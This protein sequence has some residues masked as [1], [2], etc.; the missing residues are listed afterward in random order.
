M[1]KELLEIA[2]IIKNRMEYFLVECTDAPNLE[3]IVG[4][5]R[6]TN[7]LKLADAVLKNNG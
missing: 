4:Q 1:D 3:L 7:I 5:E 6:A 2:T